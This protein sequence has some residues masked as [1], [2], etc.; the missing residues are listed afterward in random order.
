LASGGCLCDQNFTARLA[1]RRL[2]PE[3]RAGG[4]SN[5]FRPAVRLV[6]SRPPRLAM[7]CPISTG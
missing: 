1:L 5:R 2:S 4:G 3:P 7:A 6:R